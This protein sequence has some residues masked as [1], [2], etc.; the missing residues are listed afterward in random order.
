[1]IL[2]SEDQIRHM[3]QEQENFKK[4]NATMTA[5]LQEKE[6]MINEKEQQIKE[7]RNKNIHLQNFRQV[8]DYRV[9]L[10]KDERG[11]LLEHLENMD[12]HVKLL[13]KELLDEAASNKKLDERLADVEG[14]IKTYKGTIK[15]KNQVL[16]DT[17]R[18]VENFEYQIMNCIRS[19]PYEHWSD[20]LT[21]IYNNIFQNSSNA[22]AFLQQGSSIG[23]S[24]QEMQKNNMLENLEKNAQ[25]T[26]QDELIRQ[27]D[28]MQKKLIQITQV[29]KRIENDRDDVFLR[30]QNENTHLIKECNELRKKKYVLKEEFADL[31]KKLKDKGQ[32]IHTLNQRLDNADFTLDL[33][34]DDNN[35]DNQYG[36]LEN[37][38]QGELKQTIPIKVKENEL[39]FVRYCNEKKMKEFIETPQ[40]RFEGKKGEKLFNILIQEIK[41]QEEETQRSGSLLERIR[42]R[43]H[44]FLYTEETKAKIN[45][46][47]VTLPPLKQYEKQLQNSTM[48]FE[49]QSQLQ[50]IEPQQNSIEQERMRITDIGKKK[51][52]AKLKKLPSVEKQYANF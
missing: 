22:Q 38:G 31:Q 23:A 37:D 41:N 35:E 4:K 25:N 18:Q 2:D 8:Y 50:S 5:Q 48:P 26:I 47:Q 51:L 33:S 13:Y 40:L 45:Q 11:P 36:S 52:S 42:E 43:V 39:P 19:S 16:M 9:N 12:K 20:N 6:E 32:K 1:M 3:E 46:S 34:K 17:R 30:I 49:E 7:Y 44:N 27:R 29:N 24:I 10:L 21:N 28:F 15:K 14:K